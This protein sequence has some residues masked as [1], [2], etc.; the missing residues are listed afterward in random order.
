MPVKATLAW[1]EM[2]WLHPTTSWQHTRVKVPNASDFRLDPNFY[3]VARRV[4]TP[5]T[6]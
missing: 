2:A 6:P 3:V 4:D 1:P 5:Q